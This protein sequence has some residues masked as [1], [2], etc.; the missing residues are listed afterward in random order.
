MSSRPGGKEATVEQRTELV[1]DAPH[2]GPVHEHAGQS[3]DVELPVV[4]LTHGEVGLRFRGTENPDHP[5]VEPQAAKNRFE[6]R[7]ADRVQGQVGTAPV[8]EFEDRLAYVA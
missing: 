6:Q 5:A 7:A 4:D 3:R 2:V 1:E 8:G